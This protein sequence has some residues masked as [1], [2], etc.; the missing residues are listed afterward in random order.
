MVLVRRS[1][2]GWGRGPATIKAQWMAYLVAGSFRDESAQSTALPPVGGVIL[3]GYGVQVIGGSDHSP[4]TITAPIDQTI[5]TKLKAIG[6]TPISI[7][8]AQPETGIAPVVSA[9]TSEPATFVA[10]NAAPWTD[11]FGD[12]N[13]YE[14]TYLEVDD[15]Q[16]QPVIIAA[17]A[18]RA[19][20]GV[21]RIRP[22]LGS[23]IS[24][25]THTK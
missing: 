1:P 5:L 11:V 16:G 24:S 18:S 21:G 8:D 7:S 3:D 4:I 6:L 9:Q 12:L 2:P 15:T 13:H 19:A 20:H 23:L 10:H 25:G 17:Y 22:G 14:G